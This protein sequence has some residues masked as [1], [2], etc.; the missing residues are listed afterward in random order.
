MPGLP[1]ASEDGRGSY[2]AGGLWVPNSLNKCNSKTGVG[3]SQT[4]DNK[5]AIIIA[6]PQTTMTSIPY[7]SL[8]NNVM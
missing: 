3:A 2:S 5:Q 4:Q 6:P 1:I 7:V 8:P